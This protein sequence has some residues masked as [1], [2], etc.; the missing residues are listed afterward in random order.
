M[1]KEK[2]RPTAM[3][4]GTL[5]F[6]LAAVCIV[7]LYQIGALDDKE[8]SLLL[9][10]GAAA[11]IGALAALAGNAM[12][13]PEPNPAL[14]ALGLL[15]PLLGAGDTAYIESRIAALVATGVNAGLKAAGSETSDDTV[16]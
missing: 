12:V 1:I 10:A 6:I 9:V 16:E 7:L 4:F 3:Y 14:E 5:A 15:V 8:V 13:E 11:A 2:I